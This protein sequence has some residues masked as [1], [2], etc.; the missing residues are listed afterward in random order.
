[1]NELSVLTIIFEVY[2]LIREVCENEHREL[3]RRVGVVTDSPLK[4]KQIYIL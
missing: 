3:V 4:S 1:M 2:F